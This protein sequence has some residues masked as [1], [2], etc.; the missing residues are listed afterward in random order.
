MAVEA[1]MDYQLLVG[2]QLIPLYIWILD[3]AKYG[4][5][6]MCEYWEEEKVMISSMED[7]P[8]TYMG[9]PVP[10]TSQKVKVSKLTQGYAGNKL[11][12]V[13][14]LNWFPDPR[15][16]IKDFQKGEFCG[17]RFDLGWNEAVKGAADGRY[18][19]LDVL[20]TKVR[21]AKSNPDSNEPAGQFFPDSTLYADK[22]DM[23]FTSAL[24][25]VIELIPGEVGLGKSDY[26]EKWV[27]TLAADEVVVEAR[28]QGAYHG[29]F[30]FH[31][32][33]YEQDGY[34]LAPRSM[35][36]ILDPL[37]DTMSWLVNS[38]FH[39]VRKL[40]NDQLVYD[41]S[42]VVGKDLMNPTMGRLIRLKPSAYGTDPRLAVHQLQ[43][44][45]STQTHLVDAQVVG[46]M[47]QR[48]TGVVDSIMG[49]VNNSG[50]RSAT[51]AR[52][53][54][55]FGT[56]RL[57]M[58]AEYNGALGWNSLS[59]MLLQNTQQYYD[60]EKKFKIAGNMMNGAT[61]LMQV[62]PEDIQGFY[63][64][65]P[66]D[67][68]MPID[69]YAMANMWRELM[70]QMSQMPTLMM[71]YNLGAIFEYVAKLAGAKNIDQFKV[72]VT[73]DEQLA[74]LAQ[75]GDVVPIGGRSANRGGSGGGAEQAARIPEPGQVPSVGRTG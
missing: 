63:D 26:P 41:P 58:H 14:P 74:K 66:V 15:V 59:Q 22:T 52:T 21:Q 72:K 23:G 1:L 69:R 24:E 17:R 44:H 60:Q 73:P 53:S 50:R 16:P 64:F 13:R 65:V 27:F 71:E 6:I 5:G 28:P 12:N 32:Q 55:S 31:V 34:A 42:R 4:V 62:T 51:E 57:K 38:H 68:T 29:K 36:E 61:K 9:V 30:P 25:M 54:S 49:M 43:T 47:M 11:F 18:I 46:D 10:G 40:L 8:K 75:A 2:E 37:N 48:V 56:N 39:S 35:L 3:Q 33:E 19:N 20:K 70:A 67:G 7:R 45:D